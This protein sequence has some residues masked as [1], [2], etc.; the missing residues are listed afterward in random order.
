MVVDE[1]D[2]CR[3]KFSVFPDTPEGWEKAAR[4]IE[5]GG[6]AG[7]DMTTGDLLRCPFCR[8]AVAPD[9]ANCPKCGAEYHKP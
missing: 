3:P 6:G 4:V 1:A 5:Q 2:D 9:W 8:T 7:I